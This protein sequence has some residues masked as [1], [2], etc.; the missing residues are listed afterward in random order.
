MNYQNQREILISK[1]NL[2][3]QL[4]ETATAQASKNLTLQNN[5]LLKH[6]ERE[7]EKLDRIAPPKKE[8]KAVSTFKK[9]I[10]WLCE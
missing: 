4:N 2:F 7:L 10:R 1:I 6:Y 8:A 3:K 5:A 9:F